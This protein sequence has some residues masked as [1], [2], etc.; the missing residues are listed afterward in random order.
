MSSFNDAAAKKAA[1]IAQAKARS[2][3]PD[4]LVNSNKPKTETKI[5]FIPAEGCVNKIRIVFDNSGSMGVDKMEDA[6]K[7]TVEFLR[8]CVPNQDA[9]AVHLLEQPYERDWDDEGDVGSISK[10]GSLSPLLKTATLTSDL[11]SLASAVDS[12][13]NHATG[14]T[15]LYKT[16]QDAL[17]AVPKASRLVAFSDGVPNYDDK[18]REETTIQLALREEIPIDTVFFGSSTD[19]GFDVMK[20]LASRTKGIFLHFD[21]AKGVDFKTAFKYLSPGKR[22]MLNDDNFKAALQ[23]GDVK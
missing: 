16:C 4:A 2:I 12:K 13:A 21:P 9:V 14:G 6:K 23:R 5:E 10:L 22:F 15:P 17:N 7:G 19:N 11:L 3:K 18:N 1:L 20:R 8:N